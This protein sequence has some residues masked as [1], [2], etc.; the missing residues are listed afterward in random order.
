MKKYT[1]TSKISTWPAAREAAE[2][3]L[4]KFPRP[5]RYGTA[6]A[7]SSKDWAVSHC[8]RCRDLDGFGNDLETIC[9]WFCLRKVAVQW[10]CQTLLKRRVG[11][12]QKRLCLPSQTTEPTVHMRK[13]AFAAGA[14]PFEAGCSSRIFSSLGSRSLCSVHLFP[15]FL[16]SLLAFS[17]LFSANRPSTKKLDLPSRWV[18]PVALVD[19]VVFS[20]DLVSEVSEV[21]ST[22]DAVKAPELTTSQL[23]SK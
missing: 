17:H 8:M 5:I 14:F 22:V 15:C 21:I 11:C 1:T 20:V 2:G 10:G 19:L 4:R 9:V 16:L 7:P 23:L 18:V 3:R 12:S 13:S 6:T